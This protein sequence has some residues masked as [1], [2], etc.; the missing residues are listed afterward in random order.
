MPGPGS[1]HRS[2]PRRPRS[3]GAHG[4]QRRRAK[5]D[6]R[7]SDR[8]RCGRL[9]RWSRSVARRRRRHDRR[10]LDGVEPGR[11][12]ARD[13]RRRPLGRRLVVELWRL[14]RACGSP[15]PR[16]QARRRLTT[17]AALRS[18]LAASPRDARRAR[19]GWSTH[20]GSGLGLQHPSELQPDKRRTSPTDPLR[21]RGT[22]GRSP[23]PTVRRAPER[24]PGPASRTVSPSRP[25]KL[26]AAWRHAWL[27]SRCYQSR[28]APRSRTAVPCRHPVIRWPLAPTWRRRD[29]PLI[30]VRAGRSPVT[31]P[32][33]S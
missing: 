8:R 4:D 28:R 19:S 14:E 2:T 21:W 22:V 5:L 17:G 30:Q 16:R 20:W 13:L 11:G 29:S 32:R 15:S 18:T 27:S 6:G 24:S 12:S 25:T 31:C 9:G 23:I 26:P 1:G 10:V 3:P 33:R 7:A